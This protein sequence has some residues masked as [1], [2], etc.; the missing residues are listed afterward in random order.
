MPIYNA[1]KYIEKC[2]DSILKQSYEDFEVLLIDDGSTDNSLAICRKLQDRDVRIKVIHKKNGG[3]ADAR[4]VGLENSKG[5]YIVFVD[6]DDYVDADYLKEL[7]TLREKYNAS[8]VSCQCRYLMS[9]G[10]ITIHPGSPE[11]EIELKIDLNTADYGSWYLSGGVWCR[12]YKKTLIEKNDLLFDTTY[13]IG[14]DFVFNIQFLTIADVAI[15]TSKCLYTYVQQ[16]DSIMHT[17]NVQAGISGMYATERGRQAVAEYKKLNTQIG[18]RNLIGIVEYLQRKDVK[19]VITRSERVEAD[20]ILNAH[21]NEFGREF[22]ARLML[23][24]HFPLLMR[25]LNRIFQYDVL[26]KYRR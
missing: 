5:E 12:L 23:K 24:K 9:N 26:K 2:V 19:S 17:T 8:Y 15:A 14:C 4:N 25:I 3:E 10:D 13:K 16:E 21:V 1:E 22:K 18:R 7:Y 6:S 20:K 11:K